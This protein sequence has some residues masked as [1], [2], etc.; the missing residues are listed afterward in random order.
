MRDPTT[1]PSGPGFGLPVLL[2]QAASQKSLVSNLFV[3]PWQPPK[4]LYKIKDVI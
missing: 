4:R 2:L 1:D 3:F